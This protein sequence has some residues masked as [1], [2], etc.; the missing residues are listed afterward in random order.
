MNANVRA[1]LI[2]AGAKLPKEA[3]TAPP[4][5][6]APSPK[7]KTQTAA[8][9]AVTAKEIEEDGTPPPSIAAIH[10]IGRYQLNVANGT[11]YP[12]RARVV[13]I[14]VAGGLYEEQIKDRFRIVV[15]GDLADKEVVLERIKQ[16]IINA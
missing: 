9:Q 3:I 15:S 7:G 5:N 12:G 4:R 13:S 14:Q 11:H 8:A 16:A 10:C 2:A 6:A 1:Q